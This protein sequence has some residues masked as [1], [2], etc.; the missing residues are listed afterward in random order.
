MTEEVV[1]EEVK[2]DWMLLIV[3]ALLFGGLVILTIKGKVP[4]LGGEDP[5]PETP[6]TPD[7]DEGQIDI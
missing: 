7:V 4:Q 3:G 5:T 6:D 1:Q 2:R